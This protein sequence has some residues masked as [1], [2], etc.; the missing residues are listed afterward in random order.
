MFHANEARLIFDDD[1]IRR[2]KIPAERPKNF[3]THKQKVKKNL[4]DRMLDKSGEF[5][6]KSCVSNVSVNS[7]WVHPPW[8]TPGKI[9][10][11]DRIPAKFFCLIPCLGAKND[12]QIPQGLGE[13]F[14]KLEETLPSACEKSSRNPENYETVQIFCFENLTKLLHF[15]LKQN[16]SK[17][18]KYYS[19][20]HFN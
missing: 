7:N 5:F 13:I 20:Q 18:F 11:S 14:P 3:Y 19:L 12:G 2:A 8:T 10:S 17:V 6:L 4:N 1:G 16:H 15:R 9:F